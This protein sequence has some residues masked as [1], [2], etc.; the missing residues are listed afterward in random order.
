MNPHANSLNPAREEGETFE[1]Y[2]ERRA[3]LTK[4]AE[5]QRTH[6]TLLYKAEKG[7]PPAVR[8]ENATVPKDIV[9]ATKE[10]LK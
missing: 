5:W 6:G 2:K 4:L 8:I 7:K 10:T 1:Q 3:R 9:T